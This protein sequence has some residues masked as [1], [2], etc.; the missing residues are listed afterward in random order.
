M[1]FGGINIKTEITDGICLVTVRTEGNVMKCMDIIHNEL[2]LRKI[3]IHYLSILNYLQN[4]KTIVIAIVENDLYP[5][6]ASIGCIK[7]N[8]KISGYT[9]NCSNTLIC[10]NKQE[11]NIFDI[12]KSNESKIRF[13]YEN[14]DRGCLICESDIKQKIIS[15]IE[16]L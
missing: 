13:V 2:K 16:A 12:I 4:E 5:W 14:Y 10:W 9:L 7:E 11:K 8:A 3:K 6:L 15:K 1:Y